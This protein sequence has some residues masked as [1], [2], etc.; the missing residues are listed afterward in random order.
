M[1]A[2][3]S[4]LRR[5]GRSVAVG[6]GGAPDMTAA[7]P[8]LTHSNVA[9]AAARAKIEADLHDAGAVDGGAGGSAL[10]TP[11]LTRRPS[12]SRTIGVAAGTG[13]VTGAGAAVLASTPQSPPPAVIVVA[14]SGSPR[15]MAAAPGTASIGAGSLSRLPG[16]A[17]GSAHHHRTGS[18]G[19]G[20]AGP[21]LPSGPSSYGSVREGT[22]VDPILPH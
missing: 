13:L 14:G 21:T 5:N 12:T 18:G 9:A 22:P 16:P 19:G 3:P 17:I 11:L 15:V 8:L 2:G 10:G 20:M 4:L 6:G 1:V 7:T